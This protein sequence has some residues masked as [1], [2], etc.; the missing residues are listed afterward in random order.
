MQSIP[1]AVMRVLK[2]TVD[3]LMD[4]TQAGTDY[5]VDSF[6]FGHHL[7]PAPPERVAAVCVQFFLRM[8]V[9]PAQRH[10]PR[11]PS[12]HPPRDAPEGE[13][14]AARMVRMRGEG[15]AAEERAGVPGQLVAGTAVPGK[16]V[17]SIARLPRLVPY[18][19]TL[20]SVRLYGP[21]ACRETCQSVEI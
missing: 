16:F 9:D 4:D 7:A 2:A 3:E 5:A 18:C 8:A 14:E 1:G 20:L 6:A 15:A 13:P 10:S 19:L 12:G 11:R 17:G 21:S